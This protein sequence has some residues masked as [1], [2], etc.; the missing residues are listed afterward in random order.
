MKGKYECDHPCQRWSGDLRRG[1]DCRCQEVKGLTG[2][3]FVHVIGFDVDQAGQQ[4][5]KQVAAALDGLYSNVNNP[6]QLEEQFNQT[7][8]NAKRWAD[9]LLSS[10]QEAFD[11]KKQNY[12]D[13]NGWRFQNNDINEREATNLREA[14]QYLQKANILSLD[15]QLA[16]EEK[17]F[18]R[19]G[20]IIEEANTL[21]N[22]LIQQNEQNY[23]K[24]IED[25][26]KKFKENTTY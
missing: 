21:W 23:L 5:L 7:R 25:N 24:L 11:I 26:A 12:D 1:S 19:K 2:N 4:Q 10:N 20:I 8:Q 16:L 18:D 15:Q 9:H 17:V 6:V 3:P 14:I 22:D 13:L